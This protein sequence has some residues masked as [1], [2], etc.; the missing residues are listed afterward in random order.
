[1]GTKNNPGEFDCHANALPDEPMFVL[2]ARDQ[3]APHLVRLWA[4]LRAELIK[5]GVRPKSD[6]YM[7]DEARHCATEMEVW[8][9]LND[10]KW[11]KQ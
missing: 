3:S 10:G 5:Q 11:R 9:E 8:R 7:V 2:L 4:D 1:M 6:M